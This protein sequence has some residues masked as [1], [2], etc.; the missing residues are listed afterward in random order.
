MDPYP[1][2]CIALEFSSRQGTSS[3]YQ[4]SFLDLAV[5]YSKKRNNIFSFT[6]FSEIGDT[7]IVKHCLVHWINSNVARQSWTEERAHV[8]GP[9]QQL[10]CNGPYQ[11]TSLPLYHLLITSPIYMIVGTWAGAVFI[12]FWVFLLGFILIL[13]YLK[14]FLLYISVKDNESSLMIGCN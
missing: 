1:F 14:K 8:L 4:C 10:R 6:L 9:R 7:K 5:W 11:P 3:K 13:L 2:I 12:S